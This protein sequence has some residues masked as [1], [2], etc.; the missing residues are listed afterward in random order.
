MTLDHHVYPCLNLVGQT[1]KGPKRL[2]FSRFEAFAVFA[3][4]ANH[5]RYDDLGGSDIYR[6]YRNV[7]STFKQ[8]FS[9][10]IES[11][12]IHSLESELPVNCPLLLWSCCT[13]GAS[14]KPSFMGIA[15]MLSSF[16]LIGIAALLSH[17]LELILTQQTLPVACRW[18]SSYLF[19]FF[20]VGSLVACLHRSCCLQSPGAPLI[21][22]ESH[23]NLK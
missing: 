2:D 13:G 14:L 8:L 1:Q 15:W 6:T 3:R 4:D 20:K 21:H 7:W 22:F 12:R 19:A 23:L 9:H 11:H 18:C 17:S 16:C 10:Q 5:D